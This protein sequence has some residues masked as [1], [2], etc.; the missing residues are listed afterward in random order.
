MPFPRPVPGLVI[1]FAYSWRSEKLAGRVEGVKDRPC[2]II[3]VTRRQREEEHVVVLPITHTPPSDP[4]AAIEIPQSVKRRIGLDSERSWIVLS[5]L[6]R[7]VWP[8]PDLRPAVP[9]DPNSIIYGLLPTAL[10][11]KIRDRVLDILKSGRATVVAR[12]E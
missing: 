12:Q 10:I 2:A 1:R 5:E 11:L 3:L 9:G 7:F 4:A 6:N 8:G